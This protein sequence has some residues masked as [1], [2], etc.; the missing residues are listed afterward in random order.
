MAVQAARQVMLLAA[1]LSMTP[2]HTAPDH[3]TA[4]HIA[5]GQSAP[6]YPTPGHSSPRH[7]E[8]VTDDALRLIT[9]GTRE[10]LSQSSVPAISQDQY[11][12]IWLGTF[13]GL[14]RYD[15]HRVRSWRRG[16]QGLARD[17]V[18][19]LCIDPNGGLWVGLFDGGVHRY[20]THRN[21][22]G[23]HLLDQGGD[24]GPLPG[25]VHAC[26][27]ETDGRVWFATDTGLSQYNPNS[28]RFQHWPLAAPTDTESSQRLLNLQHDRDGRLWVLGSRALYRFENGLQRQSAPQPLAARSRFTAFTLEDDAIVIGTAD[29][30][31]WRWRWAD[32]RLQA[33]TLPGT[34][35]VPVITTMLRDRDGRLWVGT[36]ADGVLMQARP[37]AGWQQLQHRPAYPDGLPDNH[38]RSLF[39][40]REG[41]IWIGT[42]LA[43]VSRFDPLQTSFH[44]VRTDP[45]RTDS[46]PTSSVRS[47]LAEP[48][49]LWV[50]TDGGGLALSRDDGRHFVRFQRDPSQRN[51]L[52]DDHVRFVHRDRHGRLWIGTENGLNRWHNDR[53]ESVPLSKPR[54]ANDA[55][56]Q[57]RA[58]ADDPTDDSLWLG[59]FGG[60]LLHYFP[61]QQRL[62]HLLGSG[63]NDEELC[64]NRVVTLAFDLDSSLLV[65]SDD[66]GLC[67]RDRDG[68]WRRLLPRSF[69]IWALYPTADSIWIGSYGEGLLKYHRRSE[70]SYRFGASHGIGNDVIYA[71]LPD[72]QGQ[73]W[74]STNDGLFRFDPVKERADA[75]PVSAGLQ[76][77]E[78]NSGAAARGPDGRLYFGGIRGLNWFDPAAVALNSLPPR[79]TI[80][81]IDVMQRESALPA[82]AHHEL[83]LAAGQNTLALAFAA[84]HYSSPDGNRYRY[85]LLPLEPD[86]NELSG[87]AHHVQYSQLPPGHYR[88]EMRAGSAAGVWDPEGTQLEISIAPEA[89]RSPQAYALYAALA[90]LILGLLL[91]LHWRS[92]QREKALL[93]SLQQQVEQRT[94]QLQEKNRSL[95]RLNAELQ[96]ANLRLDSISVSDPLT[97][98][99]NRRLLF[100][101]L[102]KD[103]PTAL[104]RHQEAHSQLQA[105][106]QADLLFFLID[107]DHF[108]RI[109]DSF[110]HAIGD[111]VLLGIRDRLQHICR[112]QDYLVRYGGEEFLLVSRFCDR[113]AAPQLAERIRCAI[114][115]H[116]FLLSNGA[117]LVLTCSIGYAPY[118]LKLN[119]LEAYSCEQVLQVA[120]CLLYAAKHSGRDQWLGA[121]TVH[122]VK[123]E[124]LLHR[125]RENGALAVA[126]GDIELQSSQRS[127]KRLRWRAD[128][129]DW[130]TEAT[131]QSE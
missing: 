51:G 64:G 62:E 49:S 70:R 55:F 72:A 38:I 105:V 108:K 12:F 17:S 22:L 77:R 129:S 43:G 16:E 45:T 97:G 96:Q 3:I 92:R 60:G 34:A 103:A 1:L 81:R 37:D 47:I 11:G 85:R 67:R 100:R 8:V 27:A 9:L 54:G 50:G 32:N 65:G 98:L 21:R 6:G 127:L 78:F 40:S 112:E 95:E 7:T 25:R 130:P 69:S 19:S 66:G 109:N 42:W 68:N 18:N 28:D 94:E 13:D 39:Q 56:L 123:A 61:S 41:V 84:Q 90:G 20:D 57:L 110:G 73:L 104:R 71:I 120:D 46:L 31:L 122:E 107:L 114:G 33:I 128:A 88:F 119:A 52:T 124:L 101:Y 113:G 10:G 83:E 53:I 36:E 74:L 91:W 125:L 79:S 106:H 23:P 131:A 111:E 117:K 116:P 30:G 63:G 99:G 5:L 75:Y 15:G 115:D 48:G 80:T 14:N 35:P 2:G 126:N 102:E 4:G 76:D 86:W 89:W 44:L 58:I 29:A 26:L 87:G 118:P 93:A 24:R 59:T 121:S 82:H